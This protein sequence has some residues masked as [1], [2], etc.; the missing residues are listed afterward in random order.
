MMP[1]DPVG[2]LI[3]EMNLELVHLRQ[4]AAV[5][6][7]EQR[8]L[9]AGRTDRLDSLATEKVRQSRALELFAA[10]REALLRAQGYEGTFAGLAECADAAGTRSRCLLDTWTELARAGIEARHLN[11]QNGALI[12]MRLASV[13][14]RLAHLQ[15]ASGG[16]RIYDADGR[17]RGEPARR[18]LGQV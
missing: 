18:E 9:V 1:L 4:M 11:E 5:L 14:G 3:E 15:V 10:R 8:E 7:E 17:T 13:D 12:G 16:A 2:A 6:E